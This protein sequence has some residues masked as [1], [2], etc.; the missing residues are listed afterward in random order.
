MDTHKY[1]FNTLDATD[2]DKWTSLL[3]AQP[4]PMSNLTNDGFA[5]YPKTYLY[6]KDDRTLPRSFIE[7]QIPSPAWAN[8]IKTYEVDSGHLM[9]VENPVDAALA[10]S[11][12]FKHLAAWWT[13]TTRGR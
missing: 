7:S 1:F 13:R 10:I 4:L 5:A 6:A 12:S 2:S 11:D 8:V 9:Q 3:T